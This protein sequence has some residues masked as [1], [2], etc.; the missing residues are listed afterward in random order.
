MSTM[1]L[2]SILDMELRIKRR[3]DAMMPEPD[4]EEE[5]RFKSF[6]PYLDHRNFPIKDF[7]VSWI[8]ILLSGLSQL[9]LL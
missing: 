8:S 3:Q 2:T 6:N 5:A 9:E 4:P 7:A 1:N